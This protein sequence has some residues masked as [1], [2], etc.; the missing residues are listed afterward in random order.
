MSVRPAPYFHALSTV[1]F[2][3]IYLAPGQPIQSK[4]MQ[5]LFTHIRDNAEKGTYH[6]PLPR[7][8]GEVCYPRTFTKIN[9][10]DR[11]YLTKQGFHFTNSCIEWFPA[12]RT[13]CLPPAATTLKSCSGLYRNHA[14]INI[15]CC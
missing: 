13:P 2:H 8:A 12:T 9:H 6:L 15:C 3:Q 4:S 10:E 5:L 11:D 14:V 1:R 7:F